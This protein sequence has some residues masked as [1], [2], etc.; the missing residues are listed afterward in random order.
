MVRTQGWEAFQIAVLAFPPLSEL[1]SY[2][3]T[4]LKLAPALNS[5]Y[6]TSSGDVRHSELTI[7][8]IRDSIGSG[9]THH[10][11]GTKRTELQKLVSMYGNPD[12][13]PI[14]Q[15]TPD[16]VYTGMFYEAYKHASRLTGIHHD[17]FSRYTNTSVLLNGYHYSTTKWVDLDGTLVL[18]TSA[19]PKLDP[20]L[21]VRNSMI[22]PLSVK[23]P[24]TNQVM[25]FLS[26]KRAATIITL[27]LFGPKYK[28]SGDRISQVARKYNNVPFTV[29]G[30]VMSNVTRQDFFNWF[31]S[32]TTLERIQSIHPVETRSKK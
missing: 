1:K 7:Q 22:A 14:Y 32:A 8:K 23:H 15:Y 29:K 13:I 9:E 16:F 18:P 6:V 27:G 3:N 28:V 20:F 2:E 26:P 12:R 21:G 24:E 11:Y 25:F 5:I 17:Q 10:S 19:W 31:Q 30:L 4:W